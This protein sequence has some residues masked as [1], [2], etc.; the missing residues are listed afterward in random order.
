MQQVEMKRNTGLILPYLA[1][2]LILPRSADL[3]LWQLADQPVALHP[4]VYHM[5]MP[6]EEPIMVVNELKLLKILVG[7]QTEFA[8][9]GKLLAV[10]H[11]Q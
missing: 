4:H 8:S 10:K 5:Y 6:S 7:G 3:D 2:P 9:K 11:A 1:D